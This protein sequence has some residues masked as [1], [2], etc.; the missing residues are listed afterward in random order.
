[1]PAPNAMT[2]EARPE[3]EDRFDRDP[4]RRTGLWLFLQSLCRVVT[5]LM[6]GLKVYG[7]HHIP[8]TGGVLI[9]ANHQSYLDPIVLAVQLNRPVSFLAKSGLFENPFFGWLIR[10]LNAFPVRQGAG[11]VGAVKEAIRR[12]QQG[13]MLVIYPEGSRSDT[14]ELGPIEPGAALVVRRAGVT[15]VP[16][17]I[18]GSFAAWPRKHKVF[19]PAPIRV[20]YG[21]PLSI[22]GLKA[23][24]ITTLID[25]TFH[26]MLRDLRQCMNQK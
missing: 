2:T 5:S 4:L 20:L 18:E 1:M 13:H 9:L 3:N 24:E 26:Q 19:R 23:A 16:A 22:D 25:R 8:R 10:S 12:L 11:D 17:V 6:F 7:K 15:V 21:P 14:G